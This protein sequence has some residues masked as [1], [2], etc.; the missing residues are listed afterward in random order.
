MKI[1]I[2]HLVIVAFTSTLLISCSKFLEIE[3]KSQVSDNTLW[4]TSANADLFLNNIYAG[5]SGPFTTDDPGENWTDNSMASRVG[6][7]SRN[8]IALS[9]YAPNNSPSEWGQYNNVRKANLFIEKVTESELPED[10]KKIRLAEARFLRAYYYS[11]LWMSHGGIPL[12]LN[13]LNINEQGDAVFQPRNTAQET[14]Q[15][16]V[17][18]CASIAADLP[19]DVEAGRASRGSALT[20]KGWVELVWASP[21][22]N[23]NNDVSKWQAAAKTNKEVIDLKAYSLFPDYNTLHFEENNNNS[24]VIFDKQ[25]LGGTGLGSSREG[26]QG[27]WRVGGTQR[28]WGNVN[29]T[30]EL[31]DEY[32]MSNGLPID[33]PASGYNPQKP[34]ENREKRFY[35]SIIY[36][37]SEWLGFEMV[38]RQGVGSPNATD[39]SDVNEA[40]NTG[41]SLRKGLNPVYA[42]N[43]P[44]QQNSGNFV[45][46][47]YAE[48]LLSYAEAENESVG[49]TPGVYDAINQIRKRSELPP[50]KAGLS[51]DEMRKA[52]HRERRVE[53]AFEEKRWSDLIRLRLA[54]KNLN[55]QMHGMLIQRENNIWVYKI[56]PAPGGQRQFFANKNYF[57]PIPQS[58]IDRNPQ[59][60]Q[61][62]N[63]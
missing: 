62:P 3:S 42:I 41:Y 4:S 13:V 47:R 20:L 28:S 50:L 23:S 10:W 44:N 37:G 57:L 45:I 15:F 33:D 38:M 22:F 46:F 61:N 52:I 18:E 9:Q 39:L 36:D 54:E 63:Y 19:I 7:L 26:L 60:T 5:L 27:P 17:D 29:P 59:I 30:Q 1:N 34:Y 21:L 40:T 55:G 11:K 8:L 16:I 48:V 12:V 51:K 31:V 49:P 2:K 32:A 43:G 58:A 24:E 53:L 56:I 35:Q 25:Y 6:P 14:F